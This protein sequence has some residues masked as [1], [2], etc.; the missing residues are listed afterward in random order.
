MADFEV[1]ESANI[2]FLNTKLDKT[3]TM[4]A[5]NRDTVKDKTTI[6][7]NNVSAD[8]VYEQASNLQADMDKGAEN[9]KITTTPPSN[10][11]SILNSTSPIPSLLKFYPT[12]KLKGSNESNISVDTRP[13][14]FEPS[15]IDTQGCCRPFPPLYLEANVVAALNEKPGNHGLNS[16]SKEKYILNNGVLHQSSYRSHASTRRSPLIH[17]T[18]DT[19]NEDEAEY[20]QSQRRDQCIPNTGFLARPRVRNTSLEPKQ[21]GSKSISDAIQSG[22]VDTIGDD[23]GSL[24]HERSLPQP[25]DMRYSNYSSL[26]SQM[27][28]SVD[29]PEEEGNSSLR[30]YQPHSEPRNHAPAGSSSSFDVINDDGDNDDDDENGTSLNI[31]NKKFKNKS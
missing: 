11:H 21:P 29:C 2:D 7:S 15:S 18:L 23:S 12:A 30:N 10:C 27:P 17:H 20:D 26:L 24:R 25:G 5:C 3:R 13:F 16:I 4:D 8:I 19:L 28:F 31:A 1:N 14:H 9:P 6:N 22:F